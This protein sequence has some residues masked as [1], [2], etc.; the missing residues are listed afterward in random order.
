MENIKIKTSYLYPEA[1][2]LITDSA[3]LLLVFIHY[4]ENYILV[5]ISLFSL[6]HCLIKKIPQFSDSC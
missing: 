3:K 5:L 1:D 4:L 2:S 6:I